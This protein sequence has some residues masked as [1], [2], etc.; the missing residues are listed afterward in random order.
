MDEIFTMLF[1]LNRRSLFTMWLLLLL[2][3]V[4]LVLLPAVLL[5]L[6][7]AVLFA[8]FGHGG[9]LLNGT[10]VGFSFPTLLLLPTAIACWITD[11]ASVVS[12]NVA[13]IAMTAP[14]VILFIFSQIENKYL[15][16]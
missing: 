13:V 16:K 12:A 8:L 3:A 1:P 9:W 10:F 7:P 14:N 15:K 4:M 2:L 5:V 6:L 11:I